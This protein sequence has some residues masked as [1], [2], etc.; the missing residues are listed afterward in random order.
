MEDCPGTTATT[1]AD[2]PGADPGSPADRP[3]VVDRVTSGKRRFLRGDGR[4]REA[5]R[6]IALYESYR[7]ALAGTPTAGQ[8]A[9]LKSLASTTLALE[10]IAAQ[11]AQKEPADPERLVALAN[12]QGRL[13]DR[14]GI[15]PQTEAPKPDPVAEHRKRMGWDR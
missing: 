7:E 15:G 12:L 2:R 14:L 10:T 9:L 11:Q 5:R 1:P 3:K 13:L 8:E 4:S 6:W